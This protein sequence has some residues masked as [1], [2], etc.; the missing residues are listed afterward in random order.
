MEFQQIY[1]DTYPIVF[2]RVSR[3]VFASEVEEAVQDVFLKV[4]QS[5]STFDKRSSISTWVY[6][7]ATNYCLNKIRNQKRHEEL[8]TQWAAELRP[9]DIG[10]S[11]ED[12]ILLQQVWGE[13]DEDLLQVGF[14]Y[15]VDGMTQQEISEIL[16]VSER[17]VRNRLASLKKAGQRLKEKL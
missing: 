2:R 13:L 12:R 4:A 10:A 15:Y 8:L 3:F 16:D 14:Y 5:M 17:T 7:I 1:Q 6:R 9:V 11:A